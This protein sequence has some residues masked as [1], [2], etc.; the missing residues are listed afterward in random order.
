M[1][2]SITFI[3]IRNI[4]KTSF[5][6][7]NIIKNEQE[8]KEED[9]KEIKY[10]NKENDNL[11]KNKKPQVKKNNQNKKGNN[12]PEEKKIIKKLEKLEP[13]KEMIKEKSK[14]AKETNYSRKLGGFEKLEVSLMKTKTLAVNDEIE[15][16]DEGFVVVGDDFS[17]DIFNEIFLK[18][19]KYTEYL[20]EQHKKNGKYN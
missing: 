6:A 2:S 5:K 17:E 7:K 15:Y 4:F 11:G 8:K 13:L 1:D 14:E 16:N 9:I 20:E 10:E 19:K 3:I 12:K 18:P